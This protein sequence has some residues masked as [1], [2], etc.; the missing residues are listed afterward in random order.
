M[1]MLSDRIGRRPPAI[2]GV[3]GAGTTCYFFLNA[4]S[5]GNMTLAI[6]IV[7]A[8]IGW[9]LL[10]QGFNAVYPSLYP[11][12]FPANVR[13]TAVAIPNNIG[14]PIA[15]LLASLFAYIA[16]PTAENIPLI[17]GV[18]AFA[19]TCLSGLATFLSR[20]TYRIRMED[21]GNPDAIPVPKEEYNKARN[22][23]IMHSVTVAGQSHA[24]S[25]QIPS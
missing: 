4:I 21:L 11:E 1:G 15:S 25:C 17:I 24:T 2:I 18:F 23:T 22:G 8:V 13:V 20:E 5:Q 10:Y 3:I 12:L 19:V 6:V 14:V 16:P 7:Y 9:G